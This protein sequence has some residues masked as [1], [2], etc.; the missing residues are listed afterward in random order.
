MRLK[1]SLPLLLVMLIALA[2]GGLNSLADS[3][4]SASAI[5]IHVPQDYPTIGAALEA[6]PPGATIVVAPGRYDEELQ[7][8]KPV[9]LQAAGA[10]VIIGQGFIS[11]G[12]DD[13]TVS[14]FILL[15]GKG[16]G[17][18]A[19]GVQGCAL[20]N[21]RILGREVGIRLEEVNDC[22]IEGNLFLQNDLGLSGYGL[23]NSSVKDNRF[24]ENRAV[25]IELSDLWE[26]G[27][28]HENVIANNEIS[29]GRFGLFLSWMNANRVLS[30]RIH[31]VRGP[32][33]ALYGGR[34]NTLQNN[35][36]EDCHTGI[37]IWRGG[38]NRIA[39]NAVRRNRWDGLLIYES[40]ENTI[41]ENEITANGRIGIHL[42]NT[43]DNQVQ[44][45]SVRL[46]RY[47]GVITQ[48][49]HDLLQGNV[50]QDN[51]RPSGPSPEAVQ[52]RAARA[53]VVPRG[54]IAFVRGAGR[55][56]E[57]SSGA[58]ILVFTFDGRG[59]PKIKQLTH[60]DVYDGEPVWSPDGSKLAFV[61]HPAE[62]VDQLWLMN[63]DGSGAQLLIE[64][65]HNSDFPP[66]LPTEVQDLQWAPNGSELY[67]HYPAWLT[68][69]ALF[70][71][72]LDGTERLLTSATR[73]QVLRDGQLLVLQHE[74]LRGYGAGEWELMDSQGRPLR[75]LEELHDLSLY[76]SPDGR[77][78]V[79][80]AFTTEEGEAEGRWPHGAYL[81]NLE[82]GGLRQIGDPEDMEYRM[83]GINVWGQEYQTDV[84][85]IAW[86]PDSTRFAYVSD[87][88]ADCE[89]YVYD[90]LTGTE[91]QLTRN[92]VDDY[93]PCWSPD[94]GWLAFTSERDG[95]AEVYIM[96]ADGRG[97]QRLTYLPQGDR[98]PQWGLERDLF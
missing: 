34:G 18:R 28:Q 81:Y 54:K 68:G 86:A 36:I 64:Q 85:K 5:V 20:L 69:D 61:R 11:I 98:D 79:V 2:T 60:N 83:T 75:L 41:N 26:G 31:D 67:F 93:D 55:R 70:A 66:V 94:G 45:N 58:E 73:F 65:H 32:G 96:R 8:R 3:S 63:P 42:L 7:I 89:I 25:G 1:Y 95:N 97:Q 88:D 4:T 59:I 35:T 19:G 22:R 15:P 47:G 13:V 57:A 44:S 84:A 72:A 9:T 80:L 77:W 71:V 29:G 23:T 16:K 78:A 17:I 52:L 76:L 43:R 90:L 12:A 48:L 24:L 51:G 49:A 37:S 33:L 30:N 46:N 40:K 74:Y 92:N 21:N 27:P 38:E 10:G 82:T 53:S 6:A 39:K 91:R 50:E 62:M 14:G 56:G 87:R